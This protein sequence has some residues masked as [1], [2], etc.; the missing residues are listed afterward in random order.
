[1]DVSGALLEKLCLTESASFPTLA[2]LTFTSFFIF[3]F[4]A[5]CIL[6]YV[7]LYVRLVIFFYF[8]VV[9][10]KC[11]TTKIFHRYICKQNTIK[12]PTYVRTILTRRFLKIWF[13]FCSSWNLIGEL[14]LCKLIVRKKLF[15][16]SVIYKLHGYKNIS[17]A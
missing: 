9:C 6:T 5:S 17:L 1:M 8:T 16:T 7:Q 3:F 4:V 2:M 10:T 12:K 13:L 11:P 14:C 15:Y